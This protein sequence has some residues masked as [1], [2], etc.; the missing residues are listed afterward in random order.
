M[1]TISM[2]IGP[3]V[4]HLT[5]KNLECL[6][7]IEVSKSELRKEDGRNETLY[8]HIAKLKHG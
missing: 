8:V 1:K 4:Y 2:P 7:V 6:A 5:C 3:K